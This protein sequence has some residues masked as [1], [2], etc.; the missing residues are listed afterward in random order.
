MA[1]Y[2]DFAPKVLNFIAYFKKKHYFFEK[3][4]S[5]HGNCLL[6]KGEVKNIK[7]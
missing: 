1:Y 2:V 5:W 4:K 7:L 3:M 6:N